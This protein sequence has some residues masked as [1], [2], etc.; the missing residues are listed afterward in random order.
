[1]IRLPGRRFLIAVAGSALLAVAPSAAP[2]RAPRLIVLLMVDQFRADYVER[3]HAQ[4]TQG[5]KRLL[6]EGAWFRQAAYPYA[7]TVTCA[8]H[9]SVVTGTVPSTHGMILNS[10]WDRAT[11]SSV[12][13]T[14]DPQVRNIGYG[15]QVA[16]G[17]SLARL[18]GTTL[19]DELRAQLGPS[20]R[21]LAVSLKARA[22][23]PLAGHR[24]DAVVWFDEDAGSW[25]T[26]TAFTPAPVPAVRDFIT[27]HPLER[28]FGKRWERT[29]SKDAYL[30]ENPSA[31]VTAPDAMTAAFPHLLNGA[32]GDGP[33]AAFYQQWQ[34][35]PFSD[36]YLG[37]MALDL[38]SRLHFDTRGSTNLIGIGFSAL[39]KVGH[40]YGPE[41]HEVQDVLIRLDRTLGT[42]FSG[43]DRLVGAGNYVVALAGDH[44][45]APIPER[46]RA[47]G[48][49]AG[50]IDP[51]RVVSVLESALSTALGPGPHISGYVH[52]DVYLRPG[53]LE[54]LKANRS[55]LASLDAAVKSIPGVERLFPADMLED[56]AAP[57]ADSWAAFA[58]SHY[59][60]RS[61]DLTVVYQPYWVDSDTGT[62]HGTAYGYDA[63]VPVFLLG[64]GI[65]PGEYL[66]RA[67]PTDV[68]PT[69]AFLA[70]IT[71][72]R[73]DGRVLSEALAH[74]TSAAHALAPH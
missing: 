46:A 10:W 67:S 37:R 21:T 4:W 54:K 56:L 7:N 43:L 32:G 29:L 27:E 57:A 62:S 25:T 33:D 52:T 41:S 30:F 68:A 73:T 6:T 72:P 38:A 35:S 2:A 65:V 23:A 61:G 26:S 60:G 16:G 49:P 12:T 18:Q 36:D 3:Y 17:D 9:A 59:P 40:D 39:D 24:P 13:C 71:L 50:R 51:H 11:G 74:E 53:V 44:G 20:S 31:G 66:E 69:L 70:G 64:P 47:A 14:A 28:D 48:L 5:L 58:R 19:S 55:V 45:V 1:M 8:G 34:S 63:R 22:A 42:L 15:K